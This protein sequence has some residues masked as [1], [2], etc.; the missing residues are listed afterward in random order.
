MNTPNSHD[1]HDDYELRDEVDLSEMQV[2]AKGR[3]APQRRAGKNVV[4][5]DPEMTRFFPS[6]AAVNEALRLIMRAADIPLRQ[7]KGSMV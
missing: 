4:L 3:Y 5:L 6:D 1:N 7:G 2:V